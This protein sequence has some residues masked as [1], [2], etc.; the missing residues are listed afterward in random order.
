MLHKNPIS[1]CHLYHYAGNNP[2]RYT[3]PDGRD[4]WDYFLYLAEASFEDTVENTIPACWMDA[5]GR[6]GNFLSNIFSGKGRFQLVGTASFIT[7]SGELV[8]LDCGAT[9]CGERLTIKGFDRNAFCGT[10]ADLS[11]RPIVID[12]NKVSVTINA[13]SIEI[14]EDKNGEATASIGLS[15]PLPKGL[16]AGFSAK[17]SAPVADGEYG[18]FANRRNNEI[19]KKVRKHNENAKY[20]DEALKGLLMGEDEF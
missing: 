7:V 18:T 1:N 12:S 20:I 4:D 8:L 13:V 11:G 14:S 2:I 6:A 10:I 15:A 19:N 5:K 3:D 16:S 9:K 17:F